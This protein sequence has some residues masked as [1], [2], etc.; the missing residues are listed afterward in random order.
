MADYNIVEKPVFSETMAKLESTSKA[1][2]NLFNEMFQTLLDNDRFTKEQ[3]EELKK[4]VADGKKKVAAAVSEKEQATNADASFDEIS[5]NIRKIKLAKGNATASDVLQ[6]ITFSNSNGG[7]QVGTM[8]NQS[9]EALKHS[10]IAL[11]FHVY[12]DTW[13]ETGGINTF[14]HAPKGYY[15]GNTWLGIACPNLKASNLMS[16]VQIG[17]DGAIMTGTA[18]DDANAVNND[19]LEGKSAYVKGRK[20]EGGITSHARNPTAIPYIRNNNNRVEVAVPWGFYECYW[21][22]GSYE[23]LTY[24]QIA[25]TIGLHSGVLRAE[26]NICG[27]QG[28]TYVVWTGDATA[29]ASHILYGRTAWVNGKKITGEMPEWK[30]IAHT[31]NCGQTYTIPAGQHSGNGTVTANSLA[32]Q[33]SATATANDIVAGKTAWANGQKITGTIKKR[34]AVEYTIACGN[35]MVLPEGYYSRIT[36]HG[37]TLAN[38]TQGTA[39]ANDIITGKTAWVNGSK[40]TGKASGLISKEYVIYDAAVYCADIA[41]YT[42]VNITDAKYACQT[43]IFKVTIM[44]TA[45]KYEIFNGN[46]VLGDHFST[47]I[48]FIYNYKPFKLRIQVNSNG[49]VQ[50]TFDNMLD[51]SNINL[52][53]ASVYIE[54]SHILS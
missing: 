53:L 27:V 13:S 30:A 35:L 32:S 10:P 43:A 23:Y 14:L 5:D 21:E 26:Y 22:D 24:E 52:N 47:G 40:L 33:T 54:L 29:A 4:Y 7:E 2:A 38:Q 19:I 37:E 1:H 31:L 8:P 25:Q 15:D 48:S 34:D 39:T 28:D 16:G 3:V 51:A 6:G 20:I 42:F 18:T 9:L 12:G 46:V 44:D 36:L 11:G 49:N 17:T 41:A 50:C 45:N